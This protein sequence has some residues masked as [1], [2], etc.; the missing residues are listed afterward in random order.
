MSKIHWR[1]GGRIMNTYKITFDFELE[2]DCEEENINSEVHEWIFHN[3]LYPLYKI[4][5]IGE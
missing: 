5:K 3:G 2:V 4:Q 1:V